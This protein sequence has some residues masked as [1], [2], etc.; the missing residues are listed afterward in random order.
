MESEQEIGN[1]GSVWRKTEGQKQHQETTDLSPTSYLLLP[2]P[3]LTIE[4]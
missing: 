2:I 1:R 4:S 3:S